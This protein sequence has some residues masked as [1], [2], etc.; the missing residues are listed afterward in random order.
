MARRGLCARYDAHESSACS[1]RLQQCA[2]PSTAPRRYDP[3]VAVSNGLLLASQSPCLALS[4]L[5]PGGLEAVSSGNC[6]CRR[7]QSV[8]RSTL[9]SAPIGPACSRSAPPTALAPVTICFSREPAELEVGLAA[10]STCR[11]GRDASML[12]GAA[13]GRRSINLI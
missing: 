7:G 1:I 8:T 4:S 2:S 5:D 13:I 11:C 6:D 9:A 3:V 12:R 10:A